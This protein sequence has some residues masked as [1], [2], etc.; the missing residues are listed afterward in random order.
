MTWRA[1]IAMGAISSRNSDVKVSSNG[2]SERYRGCKGTPAGHIDVRERQVIR[3]CPPRSL[4]YSGPLSK[5]HFQAQTVKNLSSC[6]SKA[7]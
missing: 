7:S 1:T 3:M 4:L 5:S 6:N 2:K